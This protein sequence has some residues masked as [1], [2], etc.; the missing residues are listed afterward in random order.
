MWA[1]SAARWVRDRSRRLRY[2]QG[3][4]PRLSGSLRRLVDVS[5]LGRNLGTFELGARAGV[6]RRGLQ[7]P[8]RSSDHI[9]GE[10]RPDCWECLL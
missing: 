2:R 10:H 9:G 7:L 1:Y 4:L 5:L 3:I 6:L 8:F